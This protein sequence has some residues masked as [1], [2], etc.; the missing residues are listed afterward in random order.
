ML[1][2]ILYPKKDF[3]GAPNMDKA[4]ELYV[5]KNK[6][7]SKVIITDHIQEIEYNIIKIKKKYIIKKN[8]IKSKEFNN[9]N[10]PV[11]FN[12]NVQVPIYPS[13]NNTST[14]P[15]GPVV[16][17]PVYPPLPI[18]VQPNSVPIYPSPSR[19][20]VSPSPPPSPPRPPIGPYPEPVIPS[21]RPPP[22]PPRPP[23]VPFPD[24]VLPSPRPPVVPFP[25]PVIPS[26][27]P[28]P[29]PPR[30][31]ISDP[32]L[33]LPIDTI[34][35][36]ETITIKQSG[37]AKVNPKIKALDICVEY[38]KKIWTIVNFIYSSNKKMKYIVI[39]SRE[40]SNNIYLIPYNNIDLKTNKV[41]KRIIKKCIDLLSGSKPDSQIVDN[42]PFNIDDLDTN[43]ISIPDI[44][45]F[46]LLD[47]DE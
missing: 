37:T 41:T 34:I 32:E 21:P 18:S 17:P 22:S 24:P 16:L 31:P 38:N 45:E 35:L 8:L 3:I 9:F 28:P 47:A 6:D 19:P 4:V 25:D 46:T 15:S 12:E 14:I 13:V 5:K 2:E 26:P 43:D 11:L 36:P 20:P 27:R 23:V 30:P 39:E 10:A 33:P 29:S 42:V 1:Y 44:G 40:D 7:A